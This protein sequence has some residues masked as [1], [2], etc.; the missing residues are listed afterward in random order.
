[1]GLGRGKFMN[2]QAQ[3]QEN[4]IIEEFSTRMDKQFDQ[5]NLMWDKLIRLIITL[6]TSI[7]FGSA[8][9]ISTIF[10]EIE[11]IKIFIIYSW[12]LFFV[13]IILGIATLINEIIFIGNKARE[14]II[15]LA[16]AMNRNEADKDYSINRV[17]PEDLYVN[18]SIFWGVA[19]IVSFLISSVIFI[20]SFLYSFNVNV[21]VIWLI[22]VIGI[23]FI[24][25]MTVHFL[26]IRKK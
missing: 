14:N 2:K 18:N 22:F 20:C 21:C 5:T 3:K 25:G 12:P 15:S 11:N 13:P 19:C 6:S 7:L 23:F 8:A 4:D 16:E 9:L 10:P 17:E 26:S 1:M 24:I